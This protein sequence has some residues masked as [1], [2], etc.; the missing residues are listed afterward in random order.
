MP[1]TQGRSGGGAA[2]APLPFGDF[3]SAA[4]EVARALRAHTGWEVCIV[5]RLSGDELVVL[6]ADDLGYGIATGDRY[7][8][9]GSLCEAM[10]RD[11][12]DAIPDTEA[13]RPE[14][15]P[16]FGKGRAA[17]YLGAPILRADGSVFGTLALMNP[18]RVGPE[19]AGHRCV[20]R[21]SAR[22]LATVLAQQDRTQHEV[23]RAQQA[24]QDSLVDSLTALSN[25]RAWDRS[26]EAEEVR[27]RR[28]GNNASVVVVDVDQLKQVND[29]FGHAAGDALLRRTA[30]T[31]RRASREPDLV[32]RIGGDE[33]AVLAI[34]CGEKDAQAL[35]ARLQEA[36]AAE[37]IRASVGVATRR[38][39]GGL[40]LALKEA[41]LAMFEAKRRRAGP[42]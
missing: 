14:G 8:F 10:T 34:D 5:T 40:Q 29:R 39:R 12:L 6:A 32:G 7:H 3:D 33:F 18:A 26:L 20:V 30:E 15:A 35:R 22:L 28:Y 38:P 41:D 2:A 36:L 23:R 13:L 4:A 21:L 31:L 17:A 37:G 1:N 24:E 11:G 16:R 25:R 9:A 27:C 42:G 19:M